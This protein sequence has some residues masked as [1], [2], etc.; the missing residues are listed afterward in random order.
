MFDP[1]RDSIEYRS[2]ADRVIGADS[3]LAIE[4]IRLREAEKKADIS[5]GLELPKKRDRQL[6]KPDRQP[7]KRGE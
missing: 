2:F 7:L 4:T 5:P 1:I 6:L 3:R